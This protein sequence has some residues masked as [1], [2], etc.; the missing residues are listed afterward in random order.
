MGK[1]NGIKVN[2]KAT[3]GGFP[4]L[5]Y[6]IRDGSTVLRLRPQH[7]LK[8]Q[9]H[10]AAAAAAGMEKVCLYCRAF[11]YDT[12]SLLG[13]SSSSLS[14]SLSVLSCFLFKRT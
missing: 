7:R 2:K 9:Q 11:D 4:Y 5:C 10:P 8:P 6:L 12:F 13:S 1:G 14:L 3:S